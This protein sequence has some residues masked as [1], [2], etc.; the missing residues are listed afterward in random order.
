VQFAWGTAKSFEAVAGTAERDAADASVV[1]GAW[2][3]GEALHTALFLEGDG[4]IGCAH[5]RRWIVRLCDVAACRRSE[6]PYRR[7]T[8][9][10]A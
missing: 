3:A 4:V 9:F 5:A 10:H 1:T 8:V 7:R 2:V 6:P